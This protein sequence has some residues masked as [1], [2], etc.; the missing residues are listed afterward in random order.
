MHTATITIETDNETRSAAEK[1]AQEHGFG[2]LNTLLSVFLKQIART[3]TVNL[4]FD[5]EEPTQY[6]LDELKAAAEDV[7]AGRVIS[8]SSGQEAADYVNSIITDEKYKRP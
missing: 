5:D 1:V 7:K 8:F 2:T 3:K 6:M 4:S